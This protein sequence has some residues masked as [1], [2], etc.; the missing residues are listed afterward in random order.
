M[1][2]EEFTD[3]DNSTPISHLKFLIKN[4][5]PSVMLYHKM[6]GFFRVNQ[7]LIPDFSFLIS[8]HRRDHRNIQRIR[9]SLIQCGEQIGHIFDIVSG[10]I[11]QIVSRIGH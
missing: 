10:R 9:M 3:S 8:I 11:K 6:G 4:Y 5:R 2:N 7:F 1:R